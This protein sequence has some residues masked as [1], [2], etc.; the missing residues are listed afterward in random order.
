M[1]ISSISAI[2]TETL[3]DAS[4]C[5]SMWIGANDFD[6]NGQFVWTDGKPFSFSRWAPGQ[7]QSLKGT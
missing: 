2:A 1:K 4:T 5:D 7:F 3:N 6:Q